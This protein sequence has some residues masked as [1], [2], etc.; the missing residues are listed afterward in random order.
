MGTNT[1]E[2]E[3]AVARTLRDSLEKLQ[4]NADEVSQAV[5]DLVSACSSARPSNS[6]PHMLRAQSSAASLAASLDVLSRFIASSL[7]QGWSFGSAQPESAP[8]V[9]SAVE[10]RPAEP[11]RAAAEPVPVPAQ[12]PPP[13]PVIATLE[14]VQEPPQ[15]Q[16]F[17]PVPAAVEETL[18]AVVAESQVPES[19]EEEVPIVASEPVPAAAPPMVAPQD[20]RSPQAAPSPVE[21]PPQE[22]PPKPKFDVAALPTDQQELHR[23]ANRVAKVTMQDIKMLRPRDVQM[24]KENHDLCSRLRDDIERA[25]KEY[26]RR[27]HAILDHPVD[28]FYS[29]MVEI[30]GEGDARALGEYPYQTPVVQR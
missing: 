17:E 3:R 24:G 30:L 22:E 21:P 5:A 13:P 16:E 12:A 11:E 10:E 7:Q 25:H 23:R 18:Y 1:T 26:E 15:E 28:Y 8:P 29:W 27:F 20:A 2:I 4:R 19:P 9:P 14:A 6:L